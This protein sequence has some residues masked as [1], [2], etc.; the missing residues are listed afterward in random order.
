M[1]YSS[2]WLLFLLL[3][4][5]S[6]SFA[7]ISW[8]QS[9]ITD[10]WTNF[11]RLD[12]K[13]PNLISSHIKF[14]HRHVF[15]TGI[16]DGIGK[17]LR[18]M[19]ETMDLEML[20]MTTTK[21]GLVNNNNNNKHTNKNI[22]HLRLDHIPFI[23]L[24]QGLPQLANHLPPWRPLDIII[25]NAGLMKFSSSTDCMNDI[26]AVNC[27]SPLL[28]TCY[29]LPNM[30][31]SSHASPTALFVSSSSHLR[32]KTYKPYKPCLST[33]SIDQKNHKYHKN[34]EDPNN[35]NHMHNQNN[36][37][38]MT[39][40]HVYSQAKSHAML[41]SAALARRFNGT[42]FT[43]KWVHPGL[44]DTPMLQGALGHINFPGRKKCSRVLMRAPCL[45]FTVSYN[46]R[47]EALII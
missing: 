9:I 23:K 20:T 7:T 28:L 3:L 4:Q 42:G 37:N 21:D 2:I 36:H 45:L 8:C 47:M 46:E 16:S 38:R 27:L 41:A 39:T 43:V 22:L 14:D 18:S 10:V 6:V 19:L 35:M 13:T 11:M 17:H 12:I 44:V 26:Y 33:T 31:S 40:H 34:N 29:L 24:G 1:K 5:L 25:H 32:Q 15:L 30:L